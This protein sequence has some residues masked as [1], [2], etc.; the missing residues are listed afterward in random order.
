MISLLYVFFSI[1]LRN[2]WHEIVRDPIRILAYFAALVRACRVKV[3]QRLYSP[4]FPHVALYEILQNFLDH[5]FRATC[6]PSTK[7]ENNRHRINEGGGGC[8]GGA[9]LDCQVLGFLED[10]RGNKTN[11]IGGRRK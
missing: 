3:P 4:I 2:V 9:G 11:E 5:E 10:S 7:T 8:L 1:H 6:A